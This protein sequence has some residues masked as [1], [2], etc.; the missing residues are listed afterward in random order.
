MVDH[1]TA[2]GDVELTDPRN[3]TAANPLGMSVTGVTAL[4]DTSAGLVE[5]VIAGHEPPL[6]IGPT[7]E[8]CRLERTGNIALG[9]DPAE[10]YDTLA[11]QMAP[12]E[13]LPPT[14]TG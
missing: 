4:A 3:Q 10:Q 12:G 6:A 8:V 2:I 9:L 13:T 14:P 1:P 11:H 7:G 5:Y